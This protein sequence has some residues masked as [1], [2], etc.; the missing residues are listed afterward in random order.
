MYV[1]RIVLAVVLA[2]ALRTVACGGEGEKPG[3]SQPPVAPN[4]APEVEPFPRLPDD[5]G[6]VARF[7][8]NR[9]H[10][11]P[12]FAEV[13]PEKAC[14]GCHQAIHAGTFDAARDDLATW[15]KHLVSLNHAPALHGA[16]RFKRAWVAKF[17]QS[18]H[19]VRPGLPATM[20]RLRLTAREAEILAE[21]LVPGDRPDDHLAAFRDDH[22]V[23]GKELFAAKQCATCHAFVTAAQT[24]ADTPGVALA[25]DLRHT[26]DRFQRIALVEYLVKPDGNMPSFGLTEEEAFALAAYI[27]TEPLPAAKTV[28]PP[29]R[30]P[31]LARDVRWPEVE[32]KVFRK[33]CWHCHA[34]PD[35]ALGDGGPGNTGGFGFPPRG[36]DLSTATGAMS[37]AIGDDGERRSVF[38]PIQGGRY[39]GIPRLVAHLLARRDEQAG[40]P[41]PDI[42]GMPL[43]LPAL[44]AEEIQ[45]VE[46]W[47]AQGRPL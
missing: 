25:P 34:Q 26:R 12:R 20:P 27:V 23:A 35:Y 22:R 24:R 5:Q 43:G 1:K 19:D 38:L 41:D 39:D 36:L 15:R 30:L 6:L 10:E 4:E 28:A 31:P 33:V 16:A 32:K 45:L 29:A 13:A 40:N 46:S 11:G 21:Y 47:I 17:L 9:C 14:V 7:E 2:A 8:C 42:F 37:G 18:P 3:P 44:S